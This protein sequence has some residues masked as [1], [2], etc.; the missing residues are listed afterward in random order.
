MSL[1]ERFHV[2]RE[3]LCFPPPNVLAALR[4]EWPRLT[5]RWN[6]GEQSWWV[7]QHG[8]PWRREAVTE[9]LRPNDSDLSDWH[10]ILAITDRRMRGMDAL[11]SRIVDE[12]RSQFIGRGREADQ[13]FLAECERERAQDDADSAT[14]FDRELAPDLSDEYYRRAAAGTHG[15]SRRVRGWRPDTASG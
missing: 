14:A 1:A 2:G 7:V 5:I 13:R 3:A 10:M 4:R 12:V 8:S 6:V 11:P 9:P 15:V